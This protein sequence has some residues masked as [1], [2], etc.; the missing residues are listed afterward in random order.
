MVDGRKMNKV[1][2]GKLLEV[3]ECFKYLW[4]HNAVYGGIDV[5]VKFT[6]NEGGKMW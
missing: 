1:L 4:S 6:M 3:E 2:K 5:E